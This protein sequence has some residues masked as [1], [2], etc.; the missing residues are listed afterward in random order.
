MGWGVE[1]ALMATAQEVT[2]VV[3]Q[4]YLVVSGGE[5]R[6]CQTPVASAVEEE[7]EEVIEIS[8]RSRAGRAVVA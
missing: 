6:D 5:A 8:T 1:E 3:Q 4:V 2:L 7:G